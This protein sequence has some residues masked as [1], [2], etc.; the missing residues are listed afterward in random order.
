M[1]RDLGREN[2]V[3]MEISLHPIF[4]AGIIVILARIYEDTRFG[5]IDGLWNLVREKAG[6]SSRGTFRCLVYIIWVGIP[7]IIGE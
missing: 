4:D 5:C 6:W 3:L 2:G 1:R 7:A